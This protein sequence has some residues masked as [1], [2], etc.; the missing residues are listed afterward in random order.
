MK[1]EALLLC[2]AALASVVGGALAGEDS[3]HRLHGVGPAWYEVKDGL[4]KL[5]AEAPDEPAP[6]NQA[7]S[8]SVNESHAA[9]S[10]WRGDSKDRDPRAKER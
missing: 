7:A 9:K 8:G 1:L 2:G 4:R 6:A 3:T 10:P 5:A